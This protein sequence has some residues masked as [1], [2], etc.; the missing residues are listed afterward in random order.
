VDPR[1]VKKFIEDLENCD[2]LVGFGQFAITL[3][4]LE[5]DS[6]VTALQKMRRHSARESAV[7]SSSRECI[8]LLKA[9]KVEKYIADEVLRLSGTE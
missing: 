1:S 7:I 6:L 3:T 8:G 9:C 4:V 5:S 2:V